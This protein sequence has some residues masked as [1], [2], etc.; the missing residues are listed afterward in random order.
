MPPKLGLGLKQVQRR[1]SA[2][3]SAINATRTKGGTEELMKFLKK[4]LSKEEK[5]ELQAMFCEDIIAG[6]IAGAASK[7]P[8]ITAKDALAESPLK[9]VKSRRKNNQM[10]RTS[11]FTRR[12]WNKHKGNPV[13]YNKHFF[14]KPPHFH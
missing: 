4:V 6:Q 10:L 1:R 11:L 9:I 5:Q 13:Y 8:K 14:R 12:T 2:L 3:K 7:N